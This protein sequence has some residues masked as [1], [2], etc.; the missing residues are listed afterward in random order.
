[1][2]E[3]NDLYG[4]LQSYRELLTEAG[5]F[6]TAYAIEKD[7]SAS[8]KKGIPYYQASLDLL[9]NT[10]AA[11][12]NQLNQQ[13]DTDDAGNYLDAAGA[14][15]ACGGVTLNQSMTE[16]EIADLLK[17]YNMQDS[18]AM[19]TGNAASED[20]GV[21]FSNSG[22]GNDTSG[23]TAGNISVSKNWANN[24]VHIVRSF[25]ETIEG[26]GIPSTAS[27]NI[28]RFV[29]AFTDTLDFNPQA[30]VPDA[31]S[32]SPMFRGSFQEMLTKISSVLGDE[33][34]NGT[35]LLDTYEGTATELNT[36]RDSVSGV[37]LNDEAMNLMMYQKSYAAACRLMTTVDEALDKLINS[38][39]TVG[40]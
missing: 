6:S 36:N 30:V 15:I 3:D 17:Q 34:R 29:A 10:L 40:R 21:L 35:V 4:S 14:T 23:I 39:G 2:L 31:D 27:D 33:I 9:A 25:T 18:R 11:K 24:S 20:T 28:D 22:D 26:G 5:E 37:D 38:T 1:V 19:V 7:S 8:I 12:F 16:A 13:Y 32:T